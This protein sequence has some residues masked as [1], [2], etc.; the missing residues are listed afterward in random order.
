VTDIKMLQC[1]CTSRKMPNYTSLF[2][3][4]V[5][6]KQSCLNIP[7]KR[8]CSS[9]R[10]QSVPGTCSR[11]LKGAVTKCWA[12]H[13]RHDHSRCWSR[14]ETAKTFYSFYTYY[15]TNHNPTSDH[16]IKAKIVRIIHEILRYVGCQIE[17]L[18]ITLSSLDSRIDCSSESVC[19]R[20]HSCCC[21]YCPV[22]III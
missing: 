5:C 22:A 9:R 11:H 12:A 13:W 2:V 17:L 18:S 16:H 4:S 8:R 20:R 10:R 14:P 15:C 19:D 3:S 21:L 1:T 6:L 7:A